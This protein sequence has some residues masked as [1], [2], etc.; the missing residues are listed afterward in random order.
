MV[1]VSPLL[2]GYGSQ[3]ANAT[4]AIWTASGALVS[5]AG[6]FGLWRAVRSG[7]LDRASYIRDERF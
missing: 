1:R 5:A 3:A 7:T 4:P 6:L 2:Q